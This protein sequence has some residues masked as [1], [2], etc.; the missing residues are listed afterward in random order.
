MYLHCSYCNIYYC[1]KSTAYIMNLGWFRF[2]HIVVDH[3]T[4]DSATL[5]SATPVIFVTSLEGHV[6]KYG[7]LT[8]DGATG[9]S[10]LVEVLDLGCHGTG[11]TTPRSIHLNST[12]VD[13]TTLCTGWRKKHPELCVTITL[14][15]YHMERNFLLRI[16]RSVC[17]VT[18]L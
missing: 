13:V 12:K 14:C 6:F 4:R 3:V 11:R 15:T 7:Q 1:G 5:T 16:C 18:Y 2:T 9:R 17:A 8:T 10:C